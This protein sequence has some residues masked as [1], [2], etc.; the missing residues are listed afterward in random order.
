MCA[1][2]RGGAALWRRNKGAVRVGCGLYLRARGCVMQL[3]VQV[4][5]TA[6][7]AAGDA[8]QWGDGLCR[9]ESV[10]WSVVGKIP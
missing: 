3:W 2:M 1:A 5:C 9:V 8:C 4:G 10:V 7:N 6:A